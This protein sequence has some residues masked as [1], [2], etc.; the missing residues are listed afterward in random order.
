V[1]GS[2]GGNVMPINGRSIKSVI[3]SQDS[4]R[5][6]TPLVTG[7][8]RRL[9]AQ[10]ASMVE[11]L[12]ASPADTYR[13]EFRFVAEHAYLSYVSSGLTASKVDRTLRDAGR[14]RNLPDH[15]I[16]AALRSA[17]NW[18]AP[19]SPDKSSEWDLPSVPD[20]DA[21][22]PEHSWVPV[23]LTDVLSGRYEPP[24]PTVG[25][26]TDGVGVL[27]PGKV[28]TAS[29]ESEAGKTWFACAIAADEC[30][31]GRHVL[32][33]DF[34]DDEAGVVGRL[35][36]FQVPSDMIRQCFHYLRPTSPVGLAGP[37]VEDLRAVIAE[38]GP[39]L[40]IID[41]ITEAMTLHGLEPLSNRD[42]ATFGRLLPR[43]MA[44]LGPAVICLDH[45]VKASENRGRYALGGVHKLNAVDGAA[46]ILE[47]RD[48]FGIRLTG[49]STISLAKDRPGQLRKHGH[50]NSTGMHVFG[51]LVVTSHDES[52]AEYEIRPVVAR[53][54]DGRAAHLMSKISAALAEHG[55]MSQRQIIATVKGKR[56]LAIDALAL[57]QRDGYVTTRTPHDL[58]KPF[59]EDAP[60]DRSPFPDCSPAVPR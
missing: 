28:H 26:R 17:R 60:G 20:V 31:D 27:Y 47:N 46:F 43:M 49:R 59:A 10:F 3:M 44:D 53:E 6:V 25:H 50:R 36:T 52:Y 34:E 2:D 51:D 14:S 55:P 56:D 29:S 54:G 19:T 39:T 8:P 32:F 42:I 22:Q 40:V 38:Y 7:R 11:R 12:Q 33:V 9:S 1:T 45:V 23:D 30:R 13:D 4:A 37:N 21:D 18:V 16:E 57:L 15:E 48:P 41:G 24:K 5:R 35:M 58:I